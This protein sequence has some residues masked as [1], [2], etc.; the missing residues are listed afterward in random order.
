MQ[1]A[2]RD[3]CVPRKF[4]LNLDISLFTVT[5]FDIR[6]DTRDVGFRWQ[7]RRLYSQSVGEDRCSGLYWRELNDQIL[8]AAALKGIRGCPQGNT[9]EVKAKAGADN[10]LAITGRVGESEA[11]CEIICIRLN[12]IG[13]KLRVVAQTSVDREV[14]SGSPLILNKEANVWVRL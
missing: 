13:Q 11:W 2:Y 9:I 14:G 5:T 6:I 10:S 12:R 8:C 4:T 3:R 7:R 1:I